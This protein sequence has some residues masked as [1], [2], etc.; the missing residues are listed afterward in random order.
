M[1][2]FF[3]ALSLLALATHTVAV[4]PPVT[5]DGQFDDW[6]HA[7]IVAIDPAGD[8]SGSFDITRLYAQTDGSMVFLRFDTGRVLNLQSGPTED[9]TLRFTFVNSRTESELTVDVRQRSVFLREG[10]DRENIG[11]YAVSYRSAP[12]YA[13]H[14]F[15]MQIDLAPLAVES[16]D[17]VELRVSGSDSLE[18]P[19]HLTIG[20]DREHGDLPPL[21][22][23]RSTGLIVR[24]ASLNTFINGMVDP[25]RSGALLR[26][27]ASNNP[28]VVLLQEEYNT[29]VED[30]QLA[31]KSGLGGDWNI[32]KV[33]DNVIASKLPL[34]NIQSLDNS[35]AAAIIETPEHG[36]VLVFSVHYKCCGAI[37]SEEDQRRIRQ[38]RALIETIDLARTR[39]GEDIPVLV[40]GDWNM[41]GS[42][43][44][45][46]MAMDPRGPDL[47][48]VDLRHAGSREV[49]T[50]FAPNSSF[51]PGILDL[52]AVDQQSS[53][54]TT[55]FLLDTRLVHPASLESFELLPDD[56]A[57]SDH[58]LMVID[59]SRSQS[60]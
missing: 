17:T 13:H 38:K 34:R 26:L 39:F 30:V 31:L 36:P 15:E 52:A 10:G 49:Y 4:T 29:S 18:A 44:P 28:D 23:G 51:A 50:W 60:E 8:A 20:E 40:A 59:L 5:I 33:R 22:M 42:R 56:S 32:V 57:A 37:G 16:G 21:D 43:S 41:V 12:T 58:L 54:W 35:Y 45:L 48:Q 1:K 27:L 24:A 9:G 2:R 53:R 14:E 19:V 7:H 55:G 11:W 47:R 6:Q 46:D 3:T 25:E